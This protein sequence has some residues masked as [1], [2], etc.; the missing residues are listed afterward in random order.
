MSRKVDHERLSLASSIDLEL[1]EAR[2]LME[3]LPGGRHLL[4]LKGDAEFNLALKRVQ[5]LREFN[6]HQVR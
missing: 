4:T 5:F 1:E 3:N 6:T 2:N